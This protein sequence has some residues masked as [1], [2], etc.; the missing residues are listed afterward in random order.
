M[1]SRE[2]V[3]DRMMYGT[4]AAIVAAEQGLHADVLTLA[5]DAIQLT[6]DAFGLRHECIRQ[7]WPEALNAA[8]AIGDI[9]AADRLLAIVADRPVGHVP[10]YL[11]AQLARF[12]AR[13]A[14]AHGSHEAVA[15]DFRAADAM[16]TEL[17]YPYP[18]ALVRRDHGVWLISRD[19]GGEARPH[20]L[21][22]EATFAA[23]GAAPAL[24]TTRELL[25][26]LPDAVTV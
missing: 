15:Q 10:P 1:H 20:L 5:D 24:A 13:L 22:A 6:L 26:S 8:L 18:L 17:G 2:D 12:R 25:R 7:C 11:R 19:R 14:A 16:L 21:A 3:Q 4:F 23:L 9:A